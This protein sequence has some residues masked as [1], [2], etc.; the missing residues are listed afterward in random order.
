MAEKK[1]AKAPRNQRPRARQTPLDVRMEAKRRYFLY[2]GHKTIAKA[3]GVSPHSVHDW[4]RDEHWREQRDAIEQEAE[5]AFIE[6]HKRELIQARREILTLGRGLI[7]QAQE[8][9][10][11]G[12]LR[13]ESV[14]DLTRVATVV[15]AAAGHSSAD[16]Q[17]AIESPDERDAK[18]PAIESAV[19]RVLANLAGSA[20]VASA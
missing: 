18:N 3:L 17:G 1:S 8:A 14:L 19:K 9:F 2:E 4:I 13:V 16:L 10:D 15:A 11:S 20:E 12:A 6:G 7:T 5:R